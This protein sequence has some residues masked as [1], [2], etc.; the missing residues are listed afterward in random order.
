MARGTLPGESL[1]I[2]NLGS[3]RISDMNKKFM[4]DRA[5]RASR[6]KLIVGR[7]GEG[8]ACDFLFR[9]GYLMVERNFHSRNGEIDIV[10]R[11]DDIFYFIEVKTRTTEKFG[12]PEEAFDWRKQK[13]IEETIGDYIFFRSLDI[14]EWRVGLIS[15]LVSGK[16]RVKIRFFCK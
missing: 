9:R 7:W 11:K 16:D 13:K 14:E 2:F 1:E 15:I 10:A 3:V 12:Q 8:I 4:V 5:L 6:H